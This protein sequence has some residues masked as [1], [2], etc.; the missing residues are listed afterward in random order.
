MRRK[1]YNI[2]LK[3][4]GPVHIGSGNT[5][6]R[7][8]YL[9]EYNRGKLHL[10]HASQFMELI[11]EK[12][13][14]DA[15]EQFILYESGK[16][17]FFDWL[18]THKILES[19]KQLAYL[20]VDIGARQ[21]INQVQECLKT[22][23]YEPYIPGS[24]IKG[25]LR[26]CILAKVLGGKSYDS[27]FDKFLQ[28]P[29]IKQ[30]QKDINRII[31][32]VEINSAM[33]SLVISDSRP[34][35]KDDLVICQKIDDSLYQRA[36]QRG[37]TLLPIYREAIGSDKTL[38]FHMTIKDNALFDL[39][40]IKVAVTE[41]YAAIAENLLTN[42]G[43]A[44]RSGQPIYIGGGSGYI[45]K[46]LIYN[47]TD[48]DRAVKVISRILAKKFNKHNHNQDTGLDLS[49]RTLKITELEGREYEMGLCYISFEETP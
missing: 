9:H 43:I 42:F 23:K 19:V 27:I 37:K 22:A 13:L 45:S 41:F 14:I 31:T 24:S 15:Y 11:I 16:T 34:L 26:T 40:Y 38:E 33:R 25:A 49:P 3:T 28:T 10:F 18:R 4:I 47:L 1:E 6:T 8:E 48:H 46:T 32:D 12:G 21:Q 39:E 17:Y 36:R 29:D 44:Q 35:A 30:L 20:T 5:K 2:K 7:N